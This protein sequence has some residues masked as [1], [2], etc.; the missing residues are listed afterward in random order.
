VKRAFL[1]ST[2][3]DGI[4]PYDISLKLQPV[5][6]KSSLWLT[7]PLTPKEKDLS[8]KYERRVLIDD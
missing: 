4:C 6:G 1:D 3:F 5:F 2:R 7:K 8:S